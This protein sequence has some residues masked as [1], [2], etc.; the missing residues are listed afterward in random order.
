MSKLKRYL[1]SKAAAKQKEGIAARV[2]HYNDLMN[3]IKKN[4]HLGI[5][6]GGVPF[7]NENIVAAG[8]KA[9]ISALKK[10]IK[11]LE[12]KFEKL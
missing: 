1:E 3:V 4:T 2:T 8:K 10:E 12:Q 6:V 11:S 5:K 7:S 9:V